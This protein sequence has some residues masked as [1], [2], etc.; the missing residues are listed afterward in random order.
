MRLLHLRLRNF[1]QHADTEIVFRS[2]L[3]GI[4]GPNGAGKST[5]LEAI[6]WSIYGAQAAR[7]TNDTIRFSRAAPRSRV[8]VELGFVLGGHE[9]RVVRT[10]SQAEVFLDGGLAPVASGLGGATRYLQ[11]RIGMSRE[12]FFNTYF[13]GQKELQFLA[14]MGPADR[15][16][17]LSQVLGYERLR[18]AQELARARRAEL[19]SEIRGL[20]A[21]LGDAE[22]SPPPAWTPSGRM[23]EALSAA[24]RR[25]DRGRRG[26]RRA[27][28]L[29][30]RWEAAQ[31]ARERARELAH[32][33]EAAETRRARAARRDIARADTELARVAEADAE[34]APLRERL[35]ELPGAAEACE[36]L[37]ELARK[38]ERRRALGAQAAE[39]EADLARGSERLS[40]L[41]SAPELEKKL[42][43]RPGAPPH[44]ARGEGAGAGGG[45]RRVADRQAGRLHQAA[46]LPRARARAEGADQA[47]RGAGSGGHLPHLRP[48]R[49]RRLRA[50]AGRAER[51]VGQPGAGRK[52]VGQPP[53][54]AG[55]EAGERLGA[56]GGVPRPRR[57]GGRECEEAHALPGRRAGAGR[58]EVRARPQGG[59]AHVAGRGAPH[60]PRR[61]RRGRAQGGRG[62]AARAAHRGDAGGA[63]G[64]GRRAPPADRA[65]PRPTPPPAPTPPP[66]APAPPP[67]NA[68]RCT[69][70]T[71]S[72]RLRTPPTP[73]PPSATAPP[74]CAR[75]SCGA[76]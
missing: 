72:T 30:P 35:K 27:A 68:R 7:G 8:E 70:P 1:R 63:A 15:G 11:S 67:P 49:R 65:R 62:P 25:A 14:A 42:R 23:T 61:L 17:F 66:S 41:E 40:K 6:A 31:A 16:R 59:A 21:V 12:E 71:T 48:P 60:P 58:A 36:R 39:L 3:T 56:G 37:A 24:R 26:R 34:L 19:R 20:R 50:A 46:E 64:G 2:G 10:L 32:A 43:R 51:A 28:A 22:A 73:P 29:T 13:T 44:R 5:I 74:S 38:D 18:R 47:D 45:A 52:V 4:I 54:A 33:V 76:G 69:T 9:Y 53:R 55:G 57:A 75:R